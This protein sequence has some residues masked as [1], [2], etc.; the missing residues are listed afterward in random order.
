MRI[1]QFLG[2]CLS[3]SSVAAAADRPVT[4]AKDV[5]PILQQK[6]QDCHQP[7][8]V[9]PMSLRTYEET[10]PWARS[11]RDRVMRRQ[12]PPWHLDKTVGVQHFKND[13]SL[14]DAQIETIVAWVDAGAP[15]GNPKDLPAA[16]PLIDQAQWGAERDG[17]GKPDIIIKSDPY[18]MAAKRPDVWWRPMSD[19]GLTEPRWVRAA[20]IRPASVPAR[21]IVHHAI[22]YLSQNDD[23]ESMNPGIITATV[24]NGNREDLEGDR[25]SQFMEWAIGE[26]YD[27]YRPGTGKL[28]MPGSKFSWDIHMHAVGEE[29]EGGV[30]MALWLYPKG[31]EP[32]HRTYSI[33]FTALKGHASLDIPPNSVVQHEG[34][35]ILKQAAVFQNFQ[36]HMHWRGKAMV[37]EALLPDGT[38]QVIN[39]VSNFNFNWMTSYI[40]ADDAAPLLPKGTIVHVVAW[41]DNTKENRFN[42]D[43]DQWV[44]YGGRT[45]DEMA[46]AWIYVNYLS[47]QEYTT[48]AAQ[49]AA[50]TKA[51]SSAVAQR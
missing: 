25:R 38:A 21:K 40:Y 49:R 28:L 41:H 51:A 35:T 33:P 34:F 31:Q 48:L 22:A 32:K 10:R 47:D 30:E 26:G 15:L 6:C 37:V 44:G 19:T 1:A 7:G 14:T 45:V 43:S 16:R 17:L 42:P 39:A 23:P 9:A 27:V 4:F 50:Q 24:N 2:V 20:E 13:M 5:A 29:L 12:M 36:P 11:I 3:V 46:H 8:S 18:T